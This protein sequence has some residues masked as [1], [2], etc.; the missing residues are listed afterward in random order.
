VVLAAP[1]LGWGVVR[2]RLQDGRRLIVG[3]ERQTEHPREV[4]VENARSPQ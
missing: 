2:N 3:G 1:E 4:V